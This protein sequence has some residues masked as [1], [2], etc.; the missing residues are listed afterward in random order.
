[1]AV[2]NADAAAPAIV[3]ITRLRPELDR[4]PDARTADFSLIWRLLT[5]TRPYATKRNWLLVS[6]VI[7]AVQLAG[8]WPG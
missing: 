7:R 3:S 4:E 1:M 8:A 2:G 5:Y 6:V